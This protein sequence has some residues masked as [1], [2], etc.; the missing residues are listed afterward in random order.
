MSPCYSPDKQLLTFSKYL[1]VLLTQPLKD[2]SDACETYLY[3]PGSQ[4]VSISI[5][6]KLT[7]E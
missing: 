1:L 5:L 6:L 2:R 3:L 7:A 4:A